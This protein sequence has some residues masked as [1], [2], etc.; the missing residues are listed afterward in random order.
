MR[1]QTVLRRWGRS[2]P[3]ITGGHNDEPKCERGRSNPLDSMRSRLTGPVIWVMISQAA[4]RWSARRA[5][6]QPTLVRITARGKTR[7]KDPAGS[8]AV[9]FA[10][11]Y[12]LAAPMGRDLSAQVAH[13]QL[14]EQHWPALLNLMRYGGFDPL[15]YSVLSSPVMALLACFCF[16]LSGRPAV[17]A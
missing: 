2:R 8:L 6:A 10:A 9:V 5:S 17:R 15:G 16:E 12:L 4:L 3:A 1:S 13:A 7:F 14:A 11:A